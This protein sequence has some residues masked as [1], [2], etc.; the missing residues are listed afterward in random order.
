MKLLSIFSKLIV[1]TLVLGN[2]L[3][4]IL[5]FVVSFERMS[6]DG[7]VLLRAIC[8]SDILVSLVILWFM[9]KSFKSKKPKH[10]NKSIIKNALK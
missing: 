6:H 9:A 10:H 7:N 3:M 2:M 1:M 5:G 8:I 4:A